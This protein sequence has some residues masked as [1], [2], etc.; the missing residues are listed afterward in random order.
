MSSAPNDFLDRIY[1]AAVVGELWPN[2]L[3]ELATIA[4]AQGGVMLTANPTTTRWVGSVGIQQLI[5]EWFREGWAQNNTRGA[6]LLAAHSAGFLREIDIFDS[7]D[8]IDNDPNI[9]EFFR[10]RG[11]GW[12]VGTIIPVPSGD[13]LIFSIERE[14]AKG[15]VEDARVR[16][17]DL[18]R[19]H[20]ARAALLSARLGL[21]RARAIAQAMQAIGLPAAVLRKGGRL[22]AANAMFE[23]LVPAVFA[24]HRHR[25][26][27][28]NRDSDRLLENALAKL[29]RGMKQGEVLS[30][31]VPAAAD[32]LPMALHLVPVC[33][34]ANDI[35]SQA[36]S[37]LIATP[38]DRSASPSAELLQGLFDL[39]PTEARVARAIGQAKSINAIAV[40][41][42]VSQSTV[43][44]QLKAIFAKTGTR[45]QVEL[46]RL[47]SGIAA[48]GS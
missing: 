45:R 33:G 12:A 2:I 9:K 29:D 16:R 10:P 40:A 47:L 19:P 42:H 32:Q 44:D 1:E 27:L 26:V 37:I 15:P 46:S 31:A 22:A 36:V 24:D 43:R 13:S 14:F 38:V 17:L 7:R 4:G 25:I 21:E 3:H 8:A 23:K 28:A 5:L 35:F 48:P 39:T 34:M 20:L 11:M 30:I 41:H 6:R 18:L